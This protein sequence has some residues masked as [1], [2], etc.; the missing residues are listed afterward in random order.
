MN[1]LFVSLNN[2]EDVNYGGG[3]C[4]RR[5]IN[6]LQQLGEVDCRIICKKSNGKSINSILTGK[7]PP[8]SNED[9]KCVMDSL[10]K[11]NIVF[12]DNSLLGNLAKC[13][14]K[15]NKKIYV[16]SFFHNVEFDYIDVRMKKGIK[17][18]LYK[19][20]AKKH[21]ELSVLYA[22]KLITLNNRDSNR[23]YEL[24]GRK[25]DSI[26]PI[27]FKDNYQE[28]EHNY[29]LAER[30]VGIFVGAFGRANYEGVKWFLQNSK[31]LNQFDFL[32][33]GREFE[34]V[35]K[36]L[37]QYGCKVIGTVDNI[38]RYYEKAEFVISPILFGGGMKVKIAEAL[39]Y[40]KTVFGT[41]E[42]FEGYE[43]TEGK[44]L[45]E[46]NSIEEFD[47]KISGWL[48]T[49]YNGF[50]KYSR[51]LYLNKYSTDVIE[52]KFRNLIIGK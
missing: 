14:K 4:S 23:L 32:I 34:T 44:S 27:S 50:N 20:L 18:F 15:T 35:K 13:V 24:Y 8:I 5:N 9:E 7:F 47:A 10:D 48:G 30:P 21:E 22:D 12:L 40:G 33:I 42:A 36:E 17:N 26:L 45:Y 25:A 49:N 39:M 37:E 2:I 41:K 11:Y 29:N 51:E 1:I 31:V 3:Q 38:G 46:C 52:K 16:I 6:V 28:R 43:D 19:K